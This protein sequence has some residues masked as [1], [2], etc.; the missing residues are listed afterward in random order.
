MG[1]TAVGKTC[2]INNYMTNTFD[3]GYEA[4]VL[5]VYRGTKLINKKQVEIEIHDTSGD[6]HFG[7]NRKVTYH[8]ADCFMICV[9]AN[10][11]ASFESITKWQTEIQGVE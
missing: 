8:G 2:L 10:E 3:D 4:T 6:E 11:P 1:D 5:D 7:V 9:A